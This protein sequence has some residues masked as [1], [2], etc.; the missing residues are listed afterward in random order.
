[1]EDALHCQAEW[2]IRTEVGSCLGVEFA[3]TP[4]QTCLGTCR[5]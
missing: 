1:M 4:P 5:L 2:P 3:G